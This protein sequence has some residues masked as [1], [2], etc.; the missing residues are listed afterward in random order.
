M[1]ELADVIESNRKVPSTARPAALST[2][3][4]ADPDRIW[5]KAANSAGVNLSPTLTVL[6]VPPTTIVAVWPGCI[7]SLETVT[8]VLAEDRFRETDRARGTGADCDHA[9]GAH[10]KQAR[11]IA[12]T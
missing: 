10:S 1:P 7:V 9:L 4:C 11:K 6:F 8:D 3:L 2:R 12:K 5:D